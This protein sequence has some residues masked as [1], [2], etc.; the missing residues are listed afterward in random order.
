MNN[1][2]VSTWTTCCRADERYLGGKMVFR[3]C[4]VSWLLVSIWAGFA[5]GKGGM[6]QVFVGFWGLPLALDP[7]SITY[8]NLCYKLKK[9]I[10]CIYPCL[11]N[12]IYFFRIEIL[13]LAPFASNGCLRFSIFNSCHFLNS[14]S[15]TRKVTTLPVNSSVKGWGG[16]CDNPTTLTIFKVTMTFDLQNVRSSPSCPKMWILE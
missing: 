7:Y 13:T 2:T 12:T 14:A 4:S 6:G 5:L 16:A 3:I 11:F 9:N 8:R 1:S 15:P 10:K